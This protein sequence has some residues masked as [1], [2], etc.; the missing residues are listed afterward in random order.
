MKSEQLTTIFYASNNQKQATNYDEN[1]IVE[2]NSTMLKAKSLAKIY[3]KC[4]FVV[5]E[6]FCFKE[7]SMQI[8]S[9]MQ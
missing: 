3:E 6:S 9:M 5:N 4:S 8:E 1:H 2:S 7:A